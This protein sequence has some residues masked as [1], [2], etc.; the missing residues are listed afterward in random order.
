M[1]YEIANIILDELL[2]EAIDKDI[3]NSFDEDRDN[4]RTMSWKDGYRCGM[5]DL[6]QIIRTKY[7]EIQDKYLAELKKETI[8]A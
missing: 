4:P 8:D 1:K 5:L 2:G 3:F 7:F 6:E